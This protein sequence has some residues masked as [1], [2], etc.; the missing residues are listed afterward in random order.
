MDKNTSGHTGKPPLIVSIPP[1]KSQPEREALLQQIV[2]KLKDDWNPSEIGVEI[3]G[4]NQAKITLVV[5]GMPEPM[6]I[7]IPIPE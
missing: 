5:S 1:T 2:Q 6:T 3:V 7:N 4:A